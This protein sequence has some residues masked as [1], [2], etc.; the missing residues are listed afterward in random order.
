MKPQTLNRLMK[1]MIPGFL[2]LQATGC[3]FTTFNDVLQ[4]VLLGI[5][6]AGSLAIFQNI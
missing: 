4:T 3:S 1:L 5:T 6:A 2:L